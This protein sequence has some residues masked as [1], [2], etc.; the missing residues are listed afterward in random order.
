M[1]LYT[2]AAANTQVSWPGFIKVGGVLLNKEERWTAPG[3]AALQHA[4]VVSKTGCRSP[5]VLQIDVLCNSSADSWQM[6]AA[7]GRCRELKG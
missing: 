1:Y 4:G 6:L 7:V 2:A 5:M 3:S